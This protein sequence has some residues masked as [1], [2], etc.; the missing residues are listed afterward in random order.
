MLQGD[1]FIKGV[2][3]MWYVEIN[4]RPILTEPYQYF[5]D[6]TDACREIKKRMCGAIVNPVWID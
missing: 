1:N 5:G 4:G 3:T 2:K 6:C